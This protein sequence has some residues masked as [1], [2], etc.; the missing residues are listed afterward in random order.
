MS[1][2]DR[3][4]EDSETP[5][6]RFTD[7][8]PVGTVLD[9]EVRF[10][11]DVTGKTNLEIRGALEGSCTIEGLAR[12]AAGGTVVGDVTATDLI[13]EGRV[14]GNLV[15]SGKIELRATARIEGDLRSPSLAMAEGCLIR[16]QIDVSG[17]A[18]ENAATSFKEKR[19]SDRDPS[20]RPSDQLPFGE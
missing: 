10:V 16:G 1:L 3:L 14:E 8:R 6:R 4:E 9:A 20:A 2:F 7:R 17:G 11:G 12:I 19:R 5:A 13:V 18:G 15:A